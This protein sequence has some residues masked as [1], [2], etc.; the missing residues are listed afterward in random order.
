M[1]LLEMQKALSRLLTDEDFRDLFFADA[2]AVCSEYALSP[3]ERASLRDIDQKRVALQSHLLMHRR[4]HVGLGAFPLVG[5]VI[6]PDL[7]EIVP[8]FCKR[9]PP[10]PVEGSTVHAEAARLFTFLLEEQ[11]RTSRWPA[12]FEDLAR[13]EECLFRLGN[14]AEAWRSCER[15]WETNA[16]SS[17][18][19]TLATAESFVPVR[20]AHAELRWFAHGIE[21][22]VRAVELGAVF[23][24]SALCEVA[25]EPTALLLYKKR[26][27]AAVSALALGEPASRLVGLCDGRRSVAKVIAALATEMDV[28]GDE[29]TALAHGAL[30]LFRTLWEQGALAFEA[31]PPGPG[32]G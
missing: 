5:K 23:P 8:V 7:D 11:A 32:N 21:S 30:D 28:H 25:A 17:R 14:A 29:E 12:Y 16:A 9:F 10:A 27:S 4:F 31:Q 13:Y 24:D 3:D 19:L 20:G 26:R 22:L 6:R 1:S 2:D 18:T 15:A